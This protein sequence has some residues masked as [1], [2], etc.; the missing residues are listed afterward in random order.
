[1]PPLLAYAMQQAFGSRRSVRRKQLH[2]ETFVTQPSVE[3][4]GESILNRSPRTDETKPYFVLHGP[5]LDDPTG[6]FA[7]VIAGNAHWR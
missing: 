7:R 2:V 1:M 6:K 4:L 3:A 5:S